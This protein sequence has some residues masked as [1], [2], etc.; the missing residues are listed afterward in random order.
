MSIDTRA[1]VAIILLAF[2][3]CVVIEIVGTGLYLG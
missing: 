2:G 1:E 3:P